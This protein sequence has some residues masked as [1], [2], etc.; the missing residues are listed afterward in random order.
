M[1]LTEG[2]P[3]KRD[4]GG[5]LYGALAYQLNES[6]LDRSLRMVTIPAARRRRSSTANE[7]PLLLFDAQYYTFNS[8][9][10]AVRIE[11]NALN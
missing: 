8:Y 5:S 3:A 6:M 1:C 2:A 9:V 10:L 11:S 7:D 4:F